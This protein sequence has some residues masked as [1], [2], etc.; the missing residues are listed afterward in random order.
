M[1]KTINL[2]DYK[3]EQLGDRQLYLN[4]NNVVVAERYCGYWLYYPAAN[5]IRVV[6]DGNT[7]R[8]I[9]DD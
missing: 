5:N 7:I 4:D 9:V 1:A 8:I 3:K 2:S 6:E